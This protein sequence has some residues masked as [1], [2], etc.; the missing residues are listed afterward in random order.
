MRVSEKT[1]LNC[2]HFVGFVI[3]SGH[4]NLEIQPQIDGC[5]CIWEV[6]IHDSCKLENGLSVLKI[7]VAHDEWSL[8]TGFS[9]LKVH[10]SCTYSQ[11]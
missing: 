4:K 6:V 3:K 9:V 5:C 8:V 2:S 1:E 7:L 11:K 10:K